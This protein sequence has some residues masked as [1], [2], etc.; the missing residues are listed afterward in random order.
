MDSSLARIGADLI[1]TVWD[2]DQHC[3]AR[4]GFGEAFSIFFIL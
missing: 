2:F 4:G 3:H 1:D